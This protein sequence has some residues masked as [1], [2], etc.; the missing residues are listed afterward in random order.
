MQ[1]LF[2]RRGSDRECALIENKNAWVS[3]LRRFWRAPKV[4]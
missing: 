2:T 1:I 4:L 3:F